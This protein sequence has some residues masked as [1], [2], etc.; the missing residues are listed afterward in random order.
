LTALARRIV[1]AGGSEPDEAQHVADNL[2]LA[3]LSGHD[4]HGVG[5]LPR[6]V[7]ALQ[8]GG[9]LPNRHVQVEVDTGSMLRLNGATGY[10]QVVGKEAMK[11]GIER[12]LQHGVAV[13]ALHHAHHLGRIGHW[14]EQCLEADLLS[15]HFVN[16][17]VR[18]IVAA[19]GGLDARTGTNPVCIGIP[20]RTAPA[21]LLDFAT[22]RIA[23]G[24]TRVAH[25]RGVAVP[26]GMLLDAQG[27][28][29]TDPRHAVEPPFGA[30]LPFGEHKGFGLSL[31]A[32]LLGGA[33]SGGP[34]CHAPHPGNK[35]ILNGMFS[36]VIDPARLGTSEHFEREA[37]AYAAWL[38]ASR[39][40]PG[41][42]PVQL[43][44]QMEVEYRKQRRENGIVVDRT[45]WEEILAAANELGVG[46]AECERLA[47]A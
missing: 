3:N 26:E 4:S 39:V 27:C 14:A 25:N 28:P 24:K 8:Q 33:L 13:V 36:I 37:T 31:V 40:A 5:M 22:S 38:R 1:A 47:G 43:S 45:T 41:Q 2:V 7:A 15:L 10:G 32:E 46:R 17:V 11:L 34:T 23:Q 16:V 29:S 30:L 18:P 21:V 12:A 19:F 35:Q 20:R 42:G 6:Y 44:G 9:L